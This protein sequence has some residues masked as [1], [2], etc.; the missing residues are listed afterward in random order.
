[1]V[2]LDEETTI[3][4]SPDVVW[5]LLRDPATVA[6]C[7]PGA[8][9]AGGDDDVWRGNI[10]VKFGPT[11]AVFRGEATLDFED[12]ARRC[13][14]DGRGIDG[15][16]ASRALASCVVSVAEADGATRLHVAGEFNVTGP[17][18]GFVNAG[19]VHVARALLAEF[20]ANVAERV[21][22]Q[23]DKQVEVPAAETSGVAA[24]ASPTVSAQASLPVDRSAPVSAPVSPPA[25]LGGGR[26]ALRAL[27]S[28]LASLFG[29][30]GSR[31]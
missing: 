14:I 12:A 23:A 13:T 21:G 10:R 1:M 22:A 18:E 7:I 31:S 16:G 27:L 4:A 26:I 5:P 25:A 6:A 9:L 3:A 17:L 8:E 24:P 30:G 28:W 19:G 15:R 11:V 20:S 29:K 2:T